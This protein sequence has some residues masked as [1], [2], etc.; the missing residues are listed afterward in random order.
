MQLGMPC[1]VDPFLMIVQSLR[2]DLR[3]VICQV[4]L[5][6]VCGLLQDRSY[7]LSSRRSSWASDVAVT[8]T[9][10]LDCVFEKSWH[11]A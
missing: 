4:R 2:D 5:I 10:L 6:K 9:L 3:S 11:C 7:T 1:G 8:T